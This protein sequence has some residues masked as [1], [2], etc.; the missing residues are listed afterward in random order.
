MAIEHRFIAVTIYIGRGDSRQAINYYYA[1]AF[2]SKFLQHFL[3]F[4]L[5]GF[6]IHLSHSNAWVQNKNLLDAVSLVIKQNLAPSENWP[7]PVR[8][9]RP[10]KRHRYQF[11]RSTVASIAL[12]YSSATFEGAVA[13]R[14]DWT[15][16][17]EQSS[18]R[19]GVKEKL[20][21]MAPAKKPYFRFLR[22]LDCLTVATLFLAKSVAI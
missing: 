17:V 18:H 16:G 3:G 21:G 8:L 1:A 19:R 7:V 14:L 13:S 22:Y 11:V 4:Y 9:Q 2:G 10:E 20:R 12:S 5:K 6:Q 15:A